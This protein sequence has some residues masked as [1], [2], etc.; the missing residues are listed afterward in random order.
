M[1]SCAECETLKGRSRQICEGK[2]DLPFHTVNKYRVNWG[3][4]PMSLEVFGEVASAAARART[5][6]KVSP[7]KPRELVGTAMKKRIEGIASIKAGVGCGCNTLAGNM[8]A[9]GIAGC[10]LRRAHIV[11]ALV[12]NRDILEQSIASNRKKIAFAWKALRQATVSDV[13]HGAMTLLRAKI[14]G[15]DTERVSLEFGANWLL[16]RSIEDV[17]EQIAKAESDPKPKSKRKPQA[18]VRRTTPSPI[19]MPLSADQKR[20]HRD[21]V[22]AAKPTPD[23]FGYPPVVHFGAHLWPVRGNWQWH[24]EKWNELAAEIEGRCIVVVV[25][26]ATTDSFADV[27]VKLSDRFEVIEST[28]TE[29]GE[30][31]SFR[32]I[33]TMIPSGQ[34]DVLLYCHGKGVRAHTARSEAVRLWTE[35]MYE[36]VVF[37]HREAVHR[38]GQGYKAFGSFRTFGEMPLN[39]RNKWHYSG[40]FFAVRAK[41]LPNKAVKSGYGG[42]EA[43]PG[44][45]FRPQDCWCEFTDGPG[46]KFGY[47]IDAMYPT[48]IDAQMQWEVDRIGGP[49]CE[50]HQRELQ[51]FMQQLEPQ[52]RVLVIGSKHGGLEHQ[53]KRHVS[54]IE[55][56]SVDI[57]PQADNVQPMIVGSSASQTVQAEILKHGPFDVVFVDGD[58]SY[59]GVTADWEFAQQ[60]QPRLIAFHDIA[61]TVKHSREGCSVDILWAKIKLAGMKT[62]EKI[63]GC[64]WGGIGVVE[65]EQC[66]T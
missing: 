26:D 39:P 11:E 25:T 9:W 62:G 23:P 52:D 51:W 24:V 42:V 20:L 66:V 2:S 38:L 8:D 21:A 37:N 50:Q 36:T 19:M 12:A 22:K 35:M 14:D 46:F 43:W 47:D 45:H 3:F 17:R 15:R 31:P 54:T 65:S 16:D 4:D 40:T 1:T 60:L 34:N 27:C 63:V 29:Q 5:E 53:I 49:R 32:T 10:E 59:D 6:Q 13:A 44:D 61:S 48:I 56:L 28:N 41:H 58:H 18:R 7:E 57:A 30:N 55:T 33:Q 64:G